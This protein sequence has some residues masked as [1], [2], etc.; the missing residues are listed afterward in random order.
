MLIKYHSDFNL[1]FTDINT[2]VQI[3]AFPTVIIYTAIAWIIK[4]YRV[5]SPV[6][7]L[8][9]DLQARILVNISILEKKSIFFQF[10]L[11]IHCL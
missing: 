4:D 5:L 6:T 10:Q 11:D 3:H 1:P 7:Q 8:E 9:P 2:F